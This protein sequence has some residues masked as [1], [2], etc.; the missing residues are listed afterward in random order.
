MLLSL[1]LLIQFPATGTL[2]YHLVDATS[3]KTSWDL[4]LRYVAFSCTSYTISSYWYFKISLSWCYVT[5]TSLDFML[6]YVAFSCASCTT[7]SYVKISLPTWKVGKETQP[8]LKSTWSKVNN[9]R[10]TV[11][12][13]QESIFMFPR[14]GIARFNSEPETSWNPV[15]CIWNGTCAQREKS[16][17]CCKSLR[18]D[19]WDAWQDSQEQRDRYSGRDLVFDGVV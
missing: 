14:S 4:M 10:N 17:K 7:S 6:R 8:W 9:L 5:R 18:S 1:V 15:I 3:K 16:T 19:S 12:F 13:V 2:R 11:F